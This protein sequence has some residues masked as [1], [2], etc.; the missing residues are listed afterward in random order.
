MARI[1]GLGRGSPGTSLPHPSHVLSQEQPHAVGAQLALQRGV[2]LSKNGQIFTLKILLTSLLPPRAQTQ[3]PLSS[4]LSDPQHP[5]K[6]LLWE[7]QGVH[8]DTATAPWALCPRVSPDLSLHS[9]NLI[10]AVP[11]LSFAIFPCRSQPATGNGR[12]CREVL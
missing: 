11:G 1:L 7:G 5:Q 6:Q 9:R 8:Q 2:F 10:Q 3:L 4:A 12:C